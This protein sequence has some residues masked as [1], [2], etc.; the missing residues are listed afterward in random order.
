MAAADVSS[1]DQVGGGAETINIGLYC[2]EI[3]K[4]DASALRNNIIFCTTNSK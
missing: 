3:M 1:L 4:G 2:I